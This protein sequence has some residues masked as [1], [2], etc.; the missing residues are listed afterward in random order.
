VLGGFTEGRRV[1]EE[2]LRLAMEDGGLGEAPIVAYGSLG[3]LYVAQGDLDA[4]I[5]V[6]ESGL[7]LCR[8]AVDKGAWSDVIAGYLSEAYGLAGR[9]ADGFAL[10]QE[11]LGTSLHTGA[12]TRQN[13]TQLS[14]IYRRAGHLDEAR[15]HAHLAHELARKQKARGYEASALFQLGAVHAH[16]T[17]LDVLRAEACYREALELAEPRGMRPLVAHCHLGLAKLYR[18]GTRHEGAQEHLATATTMYRQMDMR[19]WLE[20][21]EAEMGGLA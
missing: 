21:A 17:P 14:A 1:G 12:S 9:F 5:G 7:A 8:A 4:A 2:A 11:T 20:Q 13:L 3:I 10:L 16:L 6:L 19:Y 18:S 15:Q